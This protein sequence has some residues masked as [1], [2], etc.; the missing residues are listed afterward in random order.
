VNEKVVLSPVTPTCGLEP[1]VAT[2][3]VSAEQVV[4]EPLYRITEYGA[5]PPV[6]ET[7]ADVVAVWPVS[8]A[9]GATETTGTVRTELTVKAVGT[10]YTVTVTVALSLTL[11]Q[12]S[13]VLVGEVNVNVTGDAAT[14]FCGLLAVSRSLT[15]VVSE[16][17]VVLFPLKRVTVYGVVPPLQD[18]VAITVVDWPVSMANGE[19]VNTGSKAGLTVTVT[20]TQSRSAGVPVLP[21][22]TAM[23]KELVDLIFPVEYD[24]D[25][26]PDIVF[27]VVHPR[28]VYH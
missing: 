18:T 23:E 16:V 3:V 6:Q 10:E 24:E 15:T 5:V 13:V 25:V 20:P 26:W 21:S 7:V 1:D 8:I 19:S 27:A 4:L 2:T 9:R 22:D 14:P 17:Q 12:Y 28:P 11:A